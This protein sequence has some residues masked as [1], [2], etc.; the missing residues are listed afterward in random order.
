ME[1]NK[2]LDSIVMDDEFENLVQPLS[3]IDSSRMVLKIK[4]DGRAIVRTWENIVL[5]DSAILKA[6]RELLIPCSVSRLV[7]HNRNEAISYICTE[8]LKRDDHSNEYK[9]YLIG[10][11][12]IADMKC[13]GSLKTTKFSIATR[14]GDEYN[15]SSAAVQKYGQYAAAIDFV[16]ATVPEISKYILSGKLKISHENTVELARLPKEELTMLAAI[17]AENRTTRLSYSDIKHEIR[18]KNYT[19]STKPRPNT[20]QNENLAIKKMPKYDPDAQ[21]SSLALTIPSWISSINRAKN[22]T[23]FSET[24]RDGLYKLKEQLYSLIDAINAIITAMEV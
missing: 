14:L 7:F 15:I 21:I 5:N 10:K 8:E 9:K 20:Q 19:A 17:I 18:W 4:Q 16:F 11:R 12:F 23:N 1:N 13:S 2:V 24:T 22:Q 6:C 3:V